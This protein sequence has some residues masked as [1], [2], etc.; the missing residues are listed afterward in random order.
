[1]SRLSNPGEATTSSSRNATRE[2]DEARIPLLRAPGPRPEEFGTTTRRGHFPP[3]VF[4]QRCVVVDH[5][6]RLRRRLMLTPEGC[7]SGL[8]L[9]P[10]SLVVCADHNRHIHGSSS[11]A[12]SPPPNLPRAS[13]DSIV[14]FR[15]QPFRGRSSSPATAAPT[16]TPALAR[17]PPSELTGIEVARVEP[18]DCGCRRPATSPQRRVRSTTTTVRDY[19]WRRSAGPRKAAQRLAFM[20]LPLDHDGG[21]RVAGSCGVGRETARDAAFRIGFDY[22]GPR[23]RPARAR[24]QP[25]GDQHPAPDRRDGVRQEV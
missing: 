25:C 5:D 22:P 3:G 15:G 10:T 17:A 8:E 23:V 7:Q 13:G 11:R 20:A 14:L 9:G 2:S 12:G 18:R 6:H 24:P 1:M 16:T 19:A 4:Q 21:R